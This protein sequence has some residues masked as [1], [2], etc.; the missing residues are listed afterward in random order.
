M[1]HGR[2]AWA[3]VC[4]MGAARPV[5]RP[6]A[7][8]ATVGLAPITGGAQE[9]DPEAEGATL[10]Q[11]KLHVRTLRAD[12]QELDAVAQ[13]RHSCRQPTATLLRARVDQ[14]RALSFYGRPLLRR[15]CTSP[16]HSSRVLDPTVR[17]LRLLAAVYRPD[18]P[19]PDSHLPGALPGA[20]Q[21][22]ALLPLPSRQRCI[23]L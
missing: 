4:P 16:Y 13:W 6:G 12:R 22:L 20:P 10:L 8:R 18:A 19:G 17:I 21:S 5:H 3:G 15:W 23:D 9:E 1:P 7:L 2:A 14:T 11:K